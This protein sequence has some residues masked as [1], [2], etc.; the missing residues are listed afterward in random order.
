MDDLHGKYT[1]FVVPQDA[2]CSVARKEVIGSL[3]SRMQAKAYVLDHAFTGQMS[4]YRESGQLKSVNYI[5]NVQN[6]GEH[7]LVDIDHPLTLRLLSGRS[8]VVSVRGQQVYFGHA[9]V[10]DNM[11]YAALDGGE[12]E[13][14]SCDVI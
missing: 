8:I 10:V 12:I 3:K 9:L 14:A 7:I 4:L 11:V 2:S 13:L 1:T 5:P 6:I